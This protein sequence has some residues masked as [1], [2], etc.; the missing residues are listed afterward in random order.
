[1]RHL[2]PPPPIVLNL[3][4]VV[5]RLS[6][7]VTPPRGPRLRYRRAS[8]H[9]ITSGKHC[10]GHSGK[11]PTMRDI[12]VGIRL[13]GTGCMGRAAKVSAGLRWRIPLRNAT[14]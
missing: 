8:R 3:L 14:R 12:S 13:S 11:R 4:P 10:T 1:M 2:R 5:P 6:G 9:L 7:N